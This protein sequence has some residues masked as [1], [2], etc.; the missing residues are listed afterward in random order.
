MVQT[1]EARPTSRAART[2]LLAV[3]GLFLLVTLPVV[4]AGQPLA[5]DYHN[6]I[7]PTQVGLEGFLGESTRRLGAV[8]PA[9]FIEILV[10]APLCQR[11]PFGLVILVPLAL[12]LLV[13]L[14]LRGLLRDLDLP[15]PWPEV[16]VALWLLH[17]L[18]TEAALWPSA[19]HVQLGLALALAAL[20][21]YRRG[22]HG[23]AALAT[24]AACLSVEIMLAFPLAAWMAAPPEHRRRAAATATG[25]ALV[26]LP[27]YALWPGTDVRSAVPLADRVAALFSDPGW[28]V[29][30]PAAGLGLHSIALAV[31]WAFPASVAIL[32]LGGWVGAR[33]GP[34]LLGDG[35][36]D[37]PAPRQ[38]LLRWGAAAAALI[39]L[40][41][42]PLMVTLP[43]YHAPRT[44]TP[45]WLILAGLVP[46]AT[47]RVRWR[48]A[49]LAGAAGGLF[50]AAA[51][52]S[53]ALSVW[54]RLETAEFNQAATQ[55]LARRVPDGG[56]VAVCDV[57]RTVV[58]PAP[59][60]SFALHEFAYD[61]AAEDAMRYYAGRDAEVRLGGPLWGTRCPDPGGANLVVGFNELRR[62]AAEG[63][64]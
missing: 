64:P 33:L 18:G 50:A 48:R 29:R 56:V 4:A 20:R 19:L 52:L 53:L 16:G 30:F 40:V 8:R 36:T 2:L 55:Y 25:I 23:W 60:G 3:A 35:P 54:V 43:R 39:A 63:T 46:V 5:D 14:L 15:P 22:R 1:T 45:T 51:L 7:R 6:C 24:V 44:F 10:I 21:L 59:V 34:Q 38:V 58:T 12:T 27:A 11:V 57:P 13:G 47:S 41:N 62:A 9:R 32:A 31:W 61:W 17:P 26:L 49:P 37:P 28:Y 42:V